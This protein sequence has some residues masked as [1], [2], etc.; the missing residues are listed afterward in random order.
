MTTWY[1][2]EAGSDANLGTTEGAPVQT[3]A[4]IVSLLTAG[5]AGPHTIYSSGV[6]DPETTGW[7]SSTQLNISG[8]PTANLEGIQ[9][10]AWRTVNSAKPWAYY[11]NYRRITMTAGVSV[12]SLTGD[13]TTATVTT[14]SA[15]GLTTGRVI[16]VSG[17]SVAAFN[18]TNA[19]IT[20][21]STTTFTYPSSG[22]PSATGASYSVSPMTLVGTNTLGCNVWVASGFLASTSNK[23]RRVWVA[24]WRPN[25]PATTLT[26][27]ATSG[28]TTATAGVAAFSTSTVGSGDVGKEIIAGTGR[29]VITSV[30]STTVANVQVVN[31]RAFSSTSI[32]SGA[33]TIEN[34]NFFKRELWEGGTTNGSTNFNTV[35]NNL[36]AYGHDWTN[37]DSSG[38]ATT[39]LYVASDINPV[40]RYGTLTVLTDEKTAIMTWAGAPSGTVD[41]EIRIFGMGFQTALLYQVGANGAFKFHPDIRG[42][43]F[44]GSCVVVDDVCKNVEIGAC[45]DVAVDRIQFYSAANT[46]HVMGGGE[47][48]TVKG[49]CEL[50]GSSDGAGVTIKGSVTMA[51]GT[52][53]IT[54]IADFMHA[55]VSQLAPTGGRIHKNVLIEDGV[56]FDFRNS[57][58]GR[59]WAFNGASAS[60]FNNRVGAVLVFNQPTQS[61]PCGVNWQVS[62]GLYHG[63]ASIGDGYVLR[64]GGVSNKAGTAKAFAAYTGTGIDLADGIIADP[65]VICPDGALDVSEFNSVAISGSVTFAGFKVINPG[66]LRSHIGFGGTG[67]E[68]LSQNYAA[69]NN[70]SR[71]KVRFVNWAAAGYDATVCRFFTSSPSVNTSTAIGGL[72]NLVTAGW[73]QFPNLKAMDAARHLGQLKN[74]V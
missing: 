30:T 68:L 63:K 55:G 35:Y 32:A 31:G 70:T 61:Q 9:F 19:V 72:T 29:A 20:V 69:G 36:G 54:R 12:S 21:T 53:R 60:V 58:Y 24:D 23:V 17:A 2:D 39:N 44:Y 26:L 15:H 1:V 67:P 13:G 59:A 8:I 49:T 62:G 51:D 22:T 52:K 25:S 14:G 28:A 47:G 7:N 56:T 33:W 65:L 34:P 11:S 66:D 6:F 40:T 48:V 41:P 46:T 10:K 64:W 50:A 3:A 16:A 71:D 5:G 37:Y 27:G 74:L 38:A 18:T 57:L 43:H 42:T 4:K 45:L 73:A